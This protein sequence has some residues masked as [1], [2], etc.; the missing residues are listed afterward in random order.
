MNGQSAGK[1]FEK[2]LKLGRLVSAIEAEGHITIAWCKRKRLVQLTPRVGVCNQEK[3]WIE[4]LRDI[5]YDFN[6]GAYIWKQGNIYRL[7]W[8]G[9]KR[10]IKILDLITPYLLIKKQRAKLVK[11]FCESRLSVYANRVPYNGKEIEIFF[12]VRKLNNK[13]RIPNKE[14]RKILERIPRDYMP[15]VEMAKI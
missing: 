15:N 13:A 9:S 5:S 7:A 8:Q 1:T 12:K 6:I 3:S 14:L 10:A 4:Y 11:E 2:G